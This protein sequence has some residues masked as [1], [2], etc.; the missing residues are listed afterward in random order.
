MN[1]YPDASFV[2]FDLE[3]TGLLNTDPDILQIGAITANLT[4]SFDKYLKPLKKPTTKESTAANRLVYENGSLFKIAKDKK[5]CKTVQP[6]IGLAEFVEWL[7]LVGSGTKVLLVA[8]NAFDFD[9]IILTKKMEEFGLTSQFFNV[10]Q[11]FA[12]PLIASRE[13]YAN[14]KSRRQDAMMKHFKLISHYENQSHNAI[15]D[16]ND[17][18][19]L[20]FKMVE[21]NS[22]NKRNHQGLTWKE[23]LGKYRRTIGD[24]KTSDSFFF[25][26]SRKN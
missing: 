24:I 13:L 25:S 11:G 22:K 1:Y 17:L 21:E 20:T 18:R 2:F 16:A 10:C 12:D 6:Q 9:A 26:Y 23:F 14:L 5:L 3:T 8:Y 19:R 15:E 7:R 4:D